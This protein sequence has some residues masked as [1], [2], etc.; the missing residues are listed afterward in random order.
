[1]ISYSLKMHSYNVYDPSD[2]VV[3]ARHTGYNLVVTDDNGNATIYG[4]DLG[5]DVNNPDKA[6]ISITELTQRKKIL[7]NMKF[8]ILK[9]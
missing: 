3:I 7:T 8:I 5:P 4:V 6:Y 2:S 1:M 9:S